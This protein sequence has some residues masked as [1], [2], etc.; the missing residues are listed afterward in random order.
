MIIITL[1]VQAKLLFI[2]YET[3]LPQPVGSVG[4][5]RPG[6]A[7]KAVNRHIIWVGV[8]RIL[9]MLI[10]LSLLWSPLGAARAT[11]APPACG[12]AH[13]IAD[14]HRQPASPGKSD[15]APAESCCAAMH[16]SA[17]LLPQR[18]A[19]LLANGPLF[20]RLAPAQSVSASFRRGIH[21]ETSTPPPRL[22]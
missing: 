7:N 20:S 17:A 16:A 13:V 4:R 22:A 6:F 15:K 19:H 3:L 2:R 10:A 18:S 9:A 12:H 8:C 5:Q 11:G 14:P 1:L 21:G